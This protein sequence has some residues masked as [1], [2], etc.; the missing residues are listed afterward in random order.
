[1]V[2]TTGSP[3]D[4]SVRCA[5]LWPV[6]LR[7]AFYTKEDGPQGRGYSGYCLT[8]IRSKPP[9]MARILCTTQPSISVR[10]LRLAGAQENFAAGT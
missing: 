10:F 4:E 3:R 8:L 5:D 7:A 2:V 6:R 1:M 9:L